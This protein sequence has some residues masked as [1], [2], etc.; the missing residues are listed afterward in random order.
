MRAVL[1]AIPQLMVTPS[2]DSATPILAQVPRVPWFGAVGRPECRASSHDAAAD[3]ARAC[4]GPPQVEWLGG[5]DEAARVVRALDD[6]SSFWSDEARWRQQALTA[7]RTSGRSASLAEAL[8]R[9]SVLGYDAVR[10]AAPDEEL[11]RVA[12]GAALWTLAEAITWAVV[13]DLLAPLPN[14]FLPKLRLFELGHW[15]LGVWNGAIAIG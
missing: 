10:P 7:A 15:P 6:T 13:D 14:P 5:W 3:Y 2:V 4:G 1:R 8:H 11:A 12:A 9:L